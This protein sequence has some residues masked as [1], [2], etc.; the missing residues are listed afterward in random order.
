M[1]EYQTPLEN[2]S[3][4]KGKWFTYGGKVDENLMNTLKEVQKTAGIRKFSDF[5]NDMLKIYRENKQD[6]EPPQMQIIKKAVTDIITTT[7]SLLSAMQIIETN[8][9]KSIADYQQRIQDAEANSLQRDSIVSDLE[10]ELIGIK[11][12]L[13][14][15]Q[16]EIK[17]LHVELAAEIERKKNID[18]LINRIQQLADDA[19]AQKEKAESQLNA[20][21]DSAIEAKNKIARLEATQQDVQ[22]RLDTALAAIDRSQKELILEK[23]N[24]KKLGEALTHETILR[25]RRE[26]RLQIIEPQYQA[27]TDRLDV[28]QTETSKLRLSEQALTQKALNLELELQTATVKLQKL[29]NPLKLLNQPPEI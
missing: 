8:K 10:A 6:T 17:S 28:L 27:V 5:M 25:N 23:D 18:G 22:I 14:I 4:E 2:S 1:S 19:I 3:P 29:Q 12:E 24:N 7:E 11:K 21:L 16:Q 15:S 9:F 26:E 13:A 20:A